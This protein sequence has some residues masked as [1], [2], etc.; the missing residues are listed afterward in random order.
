MFPLRFANNSYFFSGSFEEDLNNSL[1]PILI[2]PGWQNSL[3][4][5][6]LLTLQSDLGPSG[7]LNLR[8]EV[9]K[10]K[11][12]FWL[13]TSGSTGEPKLILKSMSQLEKEIDF[14]LN[15]TSPVAFLIHENLLI[16]LTVPLCFIFGLIWGFLIPRKLKLPVSTETSKFP[17][18]SCLITVPAILQNLVQAGSPLPSFIITSGSKLQLQLTREIRNLGKSKVIEIYGS[19][20][21]GAMGFRD[22]LWKSRFTLLPRVEAETNREDLLRV[23]S[24]WVSEYSHLG[25]QLTED[26]F[27]QTQDLGDLNETGWN[28]TG[29]ADRIIK[30]NGKRISLD[31]IESLY[32]EAKICKEIAVVSVNDVEDNP[33]IHLFFSALPGKTKEDLAS[34]AKIEIPPSHQP[35]QIYEIESLPKLPNGKTDYENLKQIARKQLLGAFGFRKSEE[36]LLLPWE[37]YLK[38]IVQSMVSQAKSDKNVVDAFAFSN[39]HLIED[40]GLDSLRWHALI[41]AIEKKLGYGIP[42]EERNTAF[43]LTINGILEYLNQIESV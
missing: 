10:D 32:S 19:T 12:S 7:F 8:A 24:P 2:D 23:K 5:E 42:V 21:T 36:D 31:Q 14:W 27:F 25:T 18:N 26:G 9:Q 13:A 30:R 39:A 35:Q 22:P 16:H 11:Q 40:L 33:T 29:R 41:L 37:T 20:E 43:F 1:C 38:N 15:E 3:L 4:A 6:K 34:F 17:P 28:L